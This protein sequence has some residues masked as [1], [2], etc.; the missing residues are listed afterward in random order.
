M[1]AYGTGTTFIDFVAWPFVNYLGFTYEM[2]MMLFAWMGY[3]GCILL[4]HF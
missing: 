3:W 2:M 4:H 1:D